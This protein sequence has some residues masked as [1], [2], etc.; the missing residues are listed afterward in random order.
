MVNKRINSFKRARLIAGLTQE[1]LAE[2][3]DVSCVAVSK[4]ENGK[5]LPTAKRIKEVAQV[6]HTTVAELLND[7]EGRA[8]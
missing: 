5:T 2:K 3:L 7:S 1:Q 8:S 6:L 4:W